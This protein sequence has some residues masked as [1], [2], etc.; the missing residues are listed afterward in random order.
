MLT[1]GGRKE[2][3]LSDVIADWGEQ[4]EENLK[5]ATILFHKYTYEDYSGLAFTLYIKDGLLYEVNG[6]HCSCSGLEGQWDPELTNKSSLEMRNKW[7]R[8][9]TEALEEIGY[10]L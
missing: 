4:C 2:Y 8:Y 1:K 6:S 7:N 10:L 5:G 9:V 3:K